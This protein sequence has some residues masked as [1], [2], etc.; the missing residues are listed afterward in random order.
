MSE[1]T[2]A[3]TMNGHEIEK[4][5]DQLDFK[6]LKDMMQYYGLSGENP[7]ERIDKLRQAPDEA[8]VMFLVDLNRRLQGS[9]N[10]LVYDSPMKVGD[11]PMLHPKDR[12]RV[13]SAAIDGIRHAPE[14]VNPARVG[15]VLALTVLMT[16]PF[17]DGNGRT[18]R[19]VG[20][21]YREEF[22]QQEG[23][24][25][26]DVV[27]ESR[28]ER[29]RR[30]E[31]LVVE[32]YLPRIAFGAQADPEQVEQY[33]SD[34]LTKEDAPYVGLGGPRSPLYAEGGE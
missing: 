32:S 4:T 6:E 2:N 7:K 27:T 34:L 10:S 19:T 31:A 9:D 24:T 17:A 1:Q 29:R 30:G 8:I 11:K 18:A 22:D 26:F 12:Y 20:F 33:I 5:R 3:T 28:D 13:L 25:A 14:T 23:A 21:M 16:H 15:D